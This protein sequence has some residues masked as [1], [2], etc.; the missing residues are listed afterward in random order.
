MVMLDCKGS[1]L[2]CSHCKWNLYY[3]LVLMTVLMLSSECVM[4][5]GPV[6]RGNGTCGIKQWGQASDPAHLPA[7]GPWPLSLTHF[8]L[9]PLSVQSWRLMHS[10]LQRTQSIWSP[11]L[12]MHRCTL[13]YLRVKARSQVSSL[14]FLFASCRFTSSTQELT[15]ESLFHILNG[16]Y[17][18]IKFKTVDI[19]V[20]DTFYNL[21]E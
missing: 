14:E 19:L 21:W 18:H 10:R 1:L 12:V 3:F 6:L 15:T 2:I 17:T 9:R 11:S 7:A 5:S 8:H 20:Q 13:M 4:R 16:W